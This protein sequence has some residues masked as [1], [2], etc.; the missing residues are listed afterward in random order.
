MSE[1]KKIQLLIVVSILLLTAAC[2]E[3]SSNSKQDS[4]S[5]ANTAANST[6][7]LPRNKIEE[8]VSKGRLPPQKSAGN[9][10]GSGSGNGNEGGGGGN[11]ERLPPVT[12]QVSLAQAEQT[13]TEPTTV[14]RK[15]IR[16]ADL[17][18]EVD[19]PSDV[20]SK[21]ASIVGN[22][23]GFV[24][25]STQNSGSAA[26][27][28]RGAVT[29]T[30]RVPAAK[31]DESLQEIRGT[32]SRVIVETVKGEDVTEEFIDIEARLKTQK[33]L[34]AQ[35]LEIMKQAKTVED[36]LNVQRELADVRG[37]IEKVEGRKKF[38]ENQASFSTIKIR[39]QTPVTFSAN[40]EGFLPRL[41][42]SASGGFNFA[43]NFV[44]GLVAFL[45]GVLP[46][47]ILIV[48]PILLIIRYFWRKWRRRKIADEIVREEIKDE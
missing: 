17:Q 18:L 41:R 10:V 43:V 48:L 8:D 15:I 38:L 9:G 20:Q 6:V 44:L 30:A 40:S 46:F 39:L 31:F 47:I 42:Q 13:Q 4:Y 35:F 7:N 34:E 23:G 36:A 25:E 22:K 11:L 16:N 2:S 12:Q 29:M 27:E 14:E 37:E 1:F 26:A 33:A 3:S 21:I 19:A 45:I 32:A 5:S 24:I 28:N